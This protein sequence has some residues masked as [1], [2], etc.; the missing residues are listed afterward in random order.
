V[1][2]FSFGHSL[3]LTENRDIQTVCK[4]GRKLSSPFLALY[5]VKN[6]LDHP[7]LCVS[8]S[9]KQIPK[10]YLRHRIKRI[11]RESFRM[12]QHELPP[13]DMVVI[14]YKTLKEMDRKAIREKIDQQW[15]R[16]LGSHKKSS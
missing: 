7:R 10:A 1:P 4:K 6:T 5:S 12:K 16:L 3:H 14:I 9:K 8:V 13:A 2:S 15:Q 11:V